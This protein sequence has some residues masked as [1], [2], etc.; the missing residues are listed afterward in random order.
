MQRGR[1]VDSGNKNYQIPR[2]PGRINQKEDVG[3]AGW[4]KR[5]IPWKKHG[6]TQN[7]EAGDG[8]WYVKQALTVL[9]AAGCHSLQ[10]RHLSSSQS[11]VVILA[12]PLLFGICRNGGSDGEGGG[13]SG[14][15]SV[16]ALDS[17]KRT[18]EPDSVTLAATGT[19]CSET[20][21]KER[22]AR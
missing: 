15:V 2:P 12:A 10:P 4:P 5:S 14:R 19:D 3:Q 22:R 16:T 13:E 20:A 6:R 21:H 7:F 1:G 9:P 8:E 17:A 11:F 18:E